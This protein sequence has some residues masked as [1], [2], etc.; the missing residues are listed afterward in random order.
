MSI[1]NKIITT[2][3]VNKSVFYI[4]Y[5]IRNTWYR[6]ICY[7]L[8]PL[9]SFFLQ[10]ICLWLSELFTNRGNMSSTEWPSG[11]WQGGVWGGRGWGCGRGEWFH[12]LYRQHVQYIWGLFTFSRTRKKTCTPPGS[13]TP[14]APDPGWGGGAGVVEVY[15][16]LY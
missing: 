9:S 13:R 6:N 12:N 16:R 7:R 8:Y 10:Q 5:T 14:L 3:V 2:V 1:V 11:V 15:T 4:L